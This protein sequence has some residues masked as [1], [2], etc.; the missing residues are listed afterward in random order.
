MWIVNV[1]IIHRHD[2]GQQNESD[3]HVNASMRVSSASDCGTDSTHWHA[4]HGSLSRCV[5]AE[6]LCC[7]DLNTITDSLPVSEPV[8][9][10]DNSQQA[11]MYWH[12]PSWE[13]NS[14]I[15][16]AMATERTPLWLS[17]QDLGST[18][19]NMAVYRNWNVTYHV[20]PMTEVR[21]NEEPDVMTIKF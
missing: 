21:H 16:V 3:R 5:D 4:S 2:D 19:G 8:N 6:S 7:A 14:S 17:G 11:G 18:D 20:Y 13:A 9:G 1:D 12:S 10:V 15:S